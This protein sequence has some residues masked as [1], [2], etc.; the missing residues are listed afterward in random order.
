MEDKS[1]TNTHTSTLTHMQTYYVTPALRHVC[2]MVM[3]QTLPAAD[4]TPMSSTAEHHY[5]NWSHFHLHRL[6]S[7]QCWREDV[8]SSFLPHVAEESQT[9]LPVFF[10]SLWIKKR[11]RKYTFPISCLSFLY[12]MSIEEKPICEVTEFCLISMRN[13]IRKRVSIGCEVQ[14]CHSNL[15]SA[16]PRSFSHL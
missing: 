1:F 7:S 9:F 12:H 13:V 10:F 15:D 16:S 2:H 14:R 6:S 4:S 11:R 3:R 8:Q 5:K